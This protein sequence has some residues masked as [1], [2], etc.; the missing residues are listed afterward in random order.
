MDFKDIQKDFDWL[1]L[2]SLKL[3]NALIAERDLTGVDCACLEEY[4]CVSC[5]G[6]QALEQHEEFMKKI[7]KRQ[8]VKELIERIK[9]ET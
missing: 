3:R 6:T 1:L 4:K 2:L 5:T 7:N 8:E 9:Q